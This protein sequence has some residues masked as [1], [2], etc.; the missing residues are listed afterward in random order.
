[1]AL[2]AAVGPRSRGL[3]R[4]EGGCEGGMGGW[5]GSDDGGAEEGVPAGCEEVALVVAHSGCCLLNLGF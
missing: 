4:F 1:M 3:G 5:A 2:G